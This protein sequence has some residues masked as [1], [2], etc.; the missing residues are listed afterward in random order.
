VLVGA[1]AAYSDKVDEAAE[2]RNW[3]NLIEGDK[4]DGGEGP[5]VTDFL[6]PQRER[7]SPA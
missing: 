6:R 4:S 5:L 1:E 7:R 2:Q 3:D